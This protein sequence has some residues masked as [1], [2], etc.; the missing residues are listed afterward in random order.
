[1]LLQPLVEFLVVLFSQLAHL[2]KIGED[3][4]LVGQLGLRVQ[5]TQSGVQRVGVQTVGV[6]DDN[7]V[8]EALQNLHAHADVGKSRQSGIDGFRVQSQ[9]QHG[10]DGVGGVFNGC[11]VQK[12]NT[13][14]EIID[15]QQ[16]MTVLNLIMDGVNGL[17]GAPGNLVQ[18]VVFR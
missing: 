13:V 17:Y 18:M 11:R 10:D 15:F 1:M 5:K 8:V 2:L 9:H 7:G 3:E 16:R 4:C 6:I 14:C 12:R